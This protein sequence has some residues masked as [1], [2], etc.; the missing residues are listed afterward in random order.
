MK[1]VKLLIISTSIFAVT[2]YK[3]TE[4]ESMSKYERIG[5]IEK[6][7]E[8]FS[9]TAGKDFQKDINGINK[10]LKEIDKN[11]EVK[12][13]QEDIDEIRNLISTLENNTNEKIDQIESNLKAEIE[14]LKQDNK[15]SQEEFTKTLMNKVQVLEKMIKDMSNPTSSSFG[16]RKDF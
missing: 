5:H 6:Y 12:T 7:L 9:K 15:K 13:I 1:S 3:G 16:K 11:K 2:P 4:E 14:K 10:K 8:K